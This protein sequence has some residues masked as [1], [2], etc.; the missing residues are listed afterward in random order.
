MTT[1]PLG[2]YG[3]YTLKATL[4][5][6]VRDYVEEGDYDLLGLADAYRAQ[7][8]AE[9]AG[10]G[11]TLIDDDFYVE[12]ERL[13]EIKYALTYDDEDA[14]CPIQQ[15]IRRADLGALIGSFEKGS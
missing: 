1:T 10:T 4:L 15:A 14:S 8:N 3:R 7:I 5:D 2:G 6:D 12:V 11:I 13:P 9:L